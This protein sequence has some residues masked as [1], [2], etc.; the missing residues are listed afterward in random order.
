MPEKTLPTHLAHIE[1]EIFAFAKANKMTV[2]QAAE[3][4]TKW[5][6]KIYSLSQAT[7]SLRED[8]D[9]I[10]AV[11]TGDVEQVDLLI[12]ANNLSYFAMCIPRNRNAHLKYYDDGKYRQF[13]SEAKIL[14]DKAIQSTGIR[15][16]HYLMN[17][18]LALANSRK[19][20]AELRVLIVQEERA[21]WKAGIDPQTAGLDPREEPRKEDEHTR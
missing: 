4:L 11:C 3:W 16:I 10:T 19:R 13:V 21:L 12:S 9:L 2:P 1:K 18:C 5:R 8:I 6:N 14:R 17:H 20:E 7:G 15:R